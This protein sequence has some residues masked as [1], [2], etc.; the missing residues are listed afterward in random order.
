MTTMQTIDLN[1]QTLRNLAMLLE[2]LASN[3]LHGAKVD[4]RAAAGGLAFPLLRK[5]P[6]GGCAGPRPDR[7]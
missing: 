4:A 7:A 6:P 5:P 2:E 1:A 3:H